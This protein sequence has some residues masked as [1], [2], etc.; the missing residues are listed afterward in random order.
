M[1]RPT[2]PKQKR[3]KTKNDAVLT[4]EGGKLE[5]AVKMLKEVISWDDVNNN[6]K[7]KSDVLG[8][9]RITYTR[10]ADQ[11]KNKEEKK[12]NY[13]LALETAEDALQ[14]NPGPINKVHSVSAR[15]DYSQYLKKDAKK[16]M[17]KRALKDITTAIENLPGSKA[18]KAW[19]ASSRAKIQYALGDVNGAAKTLSNA[20]TLIFEGY[21]NELKNDDQAKLKLNVWLSGIH[22]TFAQIC[23][24]EEKV[25]LAK[26]FATSVLNV[27]DPKNML[28]ERKKEAKRI[29]DGLS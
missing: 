5:E 12:Y 19:P 27:D 28:G 13:Q 16:E 3:E 6:K 17:L 10:I 21:E 23:L 1:L 20:Q 7:G 15:L 4:R 14:I 2:D 25:I 29:L 26:H 8:H 11:T 24:D 9:L 18:H 22:L